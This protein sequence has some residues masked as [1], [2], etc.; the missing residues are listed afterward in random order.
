VVE[1]GGVVLPEHE[2][3]F[4]HFLVSVK[5]QDLGEVVVHV[6]G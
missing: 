3:V 6:E 4:K 1:F 5:Q 2:V